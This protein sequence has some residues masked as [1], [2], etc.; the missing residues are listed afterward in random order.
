MGH[1][2]NLVVHVEDLALVHAQ[3]LDA[4]L[5]GVGVDGLLEGLAQ[6]VLAAFRV[7]DQPVHGQ[8][9]VVGDQRVRGGEEAEAALDDDAL[10][11]GKPGV[12]LPQRDVRGHVD[13][14]RHPVVGAAVEV[15]LPGPVVLERHE[16]VEVGPAVDHALLIHRH[17]FARLRGQL[18]R[19][20]IEMGNRAAT[21]SRTT[22]LGA[23]PAGAAVVSTGAAATAPSGLASMMAG[24]LATVTGGGFG[25]A[26]SGT[27]AMRVAASSGSA[28]GV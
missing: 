7:G 2:R 20:A 14:L 1:G 17:A 15:L 10:V 24:A 9:Q 4:V 22:W 18:A 28:V 27:G 8:H 6:Q 19:L 21:A 5:V 23:V 26:T 25:R 13:L 11:G 16:L 12:G 3:R